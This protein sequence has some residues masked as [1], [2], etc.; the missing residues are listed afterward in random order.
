MIKQKDEKSK[1][2]KDSKDK[3]VKEKEKDHKHDYKNISAVSN[4]SQYADDSHLKVI[5]NRPDAG[6]LV[7]PIENSKPLHTNVKSVQ[8]NTSAVILQNPHMQLYNNFTNYSVCPY[9]KYIG[10]MNINLRT[11]KKQKNICC[12]MSA[13]GLFLCS[14]IPFIIKDCSDQV[15]KCPS[16]N[17]ELQVLSANKVS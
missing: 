11:S 5:E 4:R 1:N 17:E 15:Y 12:L 3:E 10:A 8:F 16:C 7:N 14:W 9:C 6:N 13:F 2:S